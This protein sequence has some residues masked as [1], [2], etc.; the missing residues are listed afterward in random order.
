ML[1]AMRFLVHHARMSFRAVLPFVALALS[2][3]AQTPSVPLGST[4]APPGT[5]PPPAP[6]PALFPQTMLQPLWKADQIGKLSALTDAPDW[7]RLSKLAKTMTLEEFDAAYNTF[8]ADDRRLPPP[9]QKDAL[10]LIVPTG[11][12]DGITMRVEFRGPQEPATKP[13]RTWRRVEELPLL[14]D[15][16]PLSDLRIALDPGHIGGGYAQMEE[17]RLSFHPE[18]KTEAV[19]EGDHVLTV[20]QILKTKLEALGAKVFLVRENS[21]PVT[22]Q[23]YNDFRDVAVRTLVQ[24]G[25]PNP[26]EQY[27]G[28]MLGMLR[29]NTVQ[30]QS[31]LLFYRVAEIHARAKKVAEQLQPD[32]VVCL[33]LNADG[34]GDFFNPQYSPNNHFHVLINGCYEADELARQDVRFEM[35]RRLFLRMHEVELPLAE[36]VAKAMARSTGL[37]PFVYV[38]QNARLVSETGYV[39]AR[40]LL[41]N[42]IYDCPVIY[43]EPYVMNNM[44]V[45][46]RLLQGPY[47]GRTLTNGRLRTSIYYDYA[48]GVV[49]GLVNYFKDKRK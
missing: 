33:H 42:R 17:R 41:A 35:L 3:R 15:R 36:S 34:G 6:A 48:N 22:T 26:P 12:S 46:Q 39:Y 40:N 7:S 44:E 13:A 2:L 4:A 29:Q 1:A 45:Y 16:P 14:N 20:A 21:E 27:N 23:R 5:T 30:W 37:P 10:G 25:I 24:K 18:N 28:T 9:W 47:E 43:L 11:T 49:E 8:Y 19:V 32:F 31:E 38:T